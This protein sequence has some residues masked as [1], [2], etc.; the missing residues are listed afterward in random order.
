[1]T[2]FFIPAALAIGL[3]LGLFGAGGGMA[4][5][6]TIMLLMDVGIK[7]AIAM[8]LW[9]VALVS[10]AAALHQRFWR[11]VQWRMLFSLSVSGVLGS[12][13][14]TQISMLIS[15]FAQLLMLIALIFFVAWWMVA[16]RL[17]TKVG[18][19]R[20]IPAIL[21]GLIIGILT[22]LL[23]VGGGFLLVPA[24]IYLGIKDFPVAVAH[25][26][27]LITLNALTGAL[28]YMGKLDVPMDTTLL[29]AAIAAIGAIFGGILLKR[30]SAEKL[31]KTFALLLCALAGGMLWGWV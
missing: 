29:I 26:L 2:L 27:V 24:L 10:F 21:V 16:V 30:L 8:S 25:S 11:V 31:Q 23:G 3:I 4:T 20:W 19:F 5:V 7:E 22:G 17:E 28:A 1:M 12:L 14:G 13:L 9:V 18:I 15:E 6:P